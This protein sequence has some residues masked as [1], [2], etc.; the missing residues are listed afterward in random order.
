MYTKKVMFDRFGKWTKEIKRENQRH[1]ILV[2]KK[3]KLFPDDENLFT[4]YTD[5][6]ESW[7]EMYASV[8]VFDQNNRDCLHDESP[9]QSKLITYFSEGI[10]N[11]KPDNNFYKVYG[12]TVKKLESTKK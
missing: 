9:V 8:L 3:V 6:T 10:K 7:T 4:V 2:W 12:S 11:L 1:P 5:G